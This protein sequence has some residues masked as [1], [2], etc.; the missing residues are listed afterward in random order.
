[1]VLRRL[2]FDQGIGVG[3]AHTMGVARQQM[4]VQLAKR[5]QREYKLARLKAKQIRR[6]LKFQDRDSG[7][8]K[9]HNKPTEA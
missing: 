5:K 8:V 6:G 2:G 9:S 1:L 7:Y 4:Q 3:G